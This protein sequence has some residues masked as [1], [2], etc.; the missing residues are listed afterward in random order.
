MNEILLMLHLFGFGAAFSS[1]V[2]NSIILMLVTSAPADAPV[3]GRVPPR[4]VRAGEVGLAFLWITGPIMIWTKHGGLGNLPWAFWVKL[5]CVIGVT[6][7]V[8]MLDV[9]LRRAQSGDEAARALIP[10]YGRVAGALLLL[11]V[12]FA[13]LAFG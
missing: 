3:L 12:I 6:A 9:L 7:V 13:V 4:L 2:G 10:F 5:L 8:I 1:A 11:V